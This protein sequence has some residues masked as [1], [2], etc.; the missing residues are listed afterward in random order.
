VTALERGLARLGAALALSG[1]A[2]SGPPDVV[3][4]WQSGTYDPENPPGVVDVSGDIEVRDPAVIRAGGVYYLFHTGDGLALKTSPDLK[5]WQAGPNVFPVNPGWIEERVPGV[6]ELWSPA[7]RFFGGTHHL[8][9]AASVFGA[10]RSC[11]GHATKADLATTDAWLDHGA[12]LCSNTT[13]TQ[14]DWNAIDPGVLV[15]SDGTPWLVFGSYQ[16]GIKLARLDTTG[17]RADT[18]MNSIAARPADG[19]ALQQG[20]LLERSGSYY[21]FTSFD[22]CCR[23]VDSTHKIMVGRASDPKGPYLDRDG[24][25]L[26]EGGGTLVLAGDARYHGPGSNVVLDGSPKNYNVYHAYDANNAGRATLRIAELAW[27]DEG[28]P[29]SGGP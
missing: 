17:A 2:C 16:G 15:A 8:Y 10:D 21:L 29:I 22:L 23:G 20:E 11:I 24:R 3:A 1:V 9:Y 25:A 6:G 27:D 12:V 18:E 4:R 13:A 7:V 19:D 14:D 28:W 26:L 5:V